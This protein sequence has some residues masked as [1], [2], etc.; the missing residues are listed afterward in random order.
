MKRIRLILETAF[1]LLAA[2]SFSEACGKVTDPAAVR[3][4]RIS[5]DEALR[6]NLRV[7]DAAAFSL[8]RDHGL[9]IGV[10]NFSEEGALE[11]LL[12]ND[13]S[14]GTIVS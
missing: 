12:R 9:H 13:T 8:C 11:R 4:D 3:F 10:F 2:L 5:F 7:M 6:K 1:L 14:A